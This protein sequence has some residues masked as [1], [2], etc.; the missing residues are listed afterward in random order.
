MYIYTADL[1]YK[2]T[3]LYLSMANLNID[4]VTQVN[5]QIILNYINIK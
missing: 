4:I 5:L 2:D 3:L 1:N